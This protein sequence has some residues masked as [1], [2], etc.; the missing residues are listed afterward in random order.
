MHIECFKYVLYVGDMPRA[1][2]FYRQAF[3]LQVKLETPHWSEVTHGDV[4][5]GLHAG[6][7]PG[8]RT[9]G[10]SLQ[11]SDLDSA[12]NEVIAAGGQVI[13]PPVARPG[14]PI[15]LAT[16]ADTEGNTLMMTQYIG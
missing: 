5:L 14:E 13:D 6:A 1:I 9:T 7:E 3:G 16:I 4:I 12:L 11:V 8:Q 2:Q 15:R 10:V